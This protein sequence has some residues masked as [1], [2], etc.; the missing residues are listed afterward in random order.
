MHLS[1]RNNA[2]SPSAFIPF[3]DFGGKTSAVGV[4]MDEFSVPVCN[5]FEATILNDQLCYEV[6]LNRFSNK[7]NIGSELKLGFN[8]L[9]DYNED[10]QVTFNRNINTSIKVDQKKEIPLYESENNDHAHIYLN[11]LG[12]F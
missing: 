12:R 4:I 6:D 8:F 7:D 10:R 11:T 5:C 3:C 9:M 2:K 1:S